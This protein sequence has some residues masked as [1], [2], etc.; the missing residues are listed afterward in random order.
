[1][2]DLQLPNWTCRISYKIPP[3]WKA[4]QPFKRLN[5]FIKRPMSTKTIERKQR[6]NLAH[7]R[8]HP[9]RRV[10]NLPKYDLTNK[11]RICHRHPVRNI[12]TAQISKGSISTPQKILT[13]SYFSLPH[14]RTNPNLPIKKLKKKLNPSSSKRLMEKE[15]LN[16]ITESCVSVTR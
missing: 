16:R 11:E 12:K 3:H 15:L 8:E 1:M 9:R 14:Q 7:K 10:S 2:W 6:D 13:F 5:F 4:S